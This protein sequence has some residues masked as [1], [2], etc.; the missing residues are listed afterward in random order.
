MSSIKTLNIES[1][2]NN[3]RDNSQEILSK[4]DNDPLLTRR[5]CP[6][7]GLRIANASKE[8]FSP[9]QEHQLFAKGIVYD[10]DG[11][12]YRLVS[13]PYI[14]MYNA[15][16]SDNV[17]R[18]AIELV[19]AGCNPIFMQK[20]DGTMISRFV[21]N[22]ASLGQPENKQV[23]FCT[24][25][26]METMT[27]DDEQANKF[28]IWVRDICKKKYPQLLNPSYL[29]AGTAI[30]ELIGPENRIITFYPEWDLVMTGFFNLEEYDYWDFECLTRWCAD[31]GIVSVG[32][33]N[34]GDKSTLE[35]KILK[36]NEVLIDT[37]NEGSVIQFELPVD[38]VATFYPLNRVLGRIK[39]KTNTYRSLLRIMNNCNYDTIAE[40][41]EKNTTYFHTWGNF[42]RH[43]E[44][45]GSANF[46]EELMESYKIFYTEYMEHR[47][48][49][50]AFVKNVHE[51]ACRLLDGGTIKWKYGIDAYD[52][53]RENRAKFAT[54]VKTKKIPGAY[55]AWLDNKLNTDYVMKKIFKT[56]E[57]SK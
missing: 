18:H 43:L 37:D 7:T 40:M 19:G 6:Q 52:L 32:S 56:P 8:L 11:V 39:A 35:D 13:L 49:C 36:M 34:F 12:N 38:K 29:S 31:A 55:F 17:R 48:R 9:T 3:I 46:P 27:A 44:S 2:L 26:M 15:D 23:V 4:I 22:M 50:E 1:L 24:R 25:G 21:V 57:E 54:Q 42:Q 16:E 51:D 28:F 10:Y 47:K 14:K 45:L 5:T 20:L 30:F 53:D 33:Y 41:I